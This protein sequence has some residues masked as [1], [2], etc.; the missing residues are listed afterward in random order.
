M[1]FQS[2]LWTLAKKTGDTALIFSLSWP[3]SKKKGAS[4]LCHEKSQAGGALL[5]CASTVIVLRCRQPG[6]DAP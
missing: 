3:K 6:H 4:D 5:I 2:V 1:N